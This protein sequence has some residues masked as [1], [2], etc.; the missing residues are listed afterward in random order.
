MIFIGNSKISG[1]IPREKFANLPTVTVLCAFRKM[2]EHMVQQLCLL[3]NMCYG[4]ST[5]WMMCILILMFWHGPGGIKYRQYSCFFC[6]IMYSYLLSKYSLMGQTFLR[7]R[8]LANAISILRTS[9]FPHRN[10]FS[11]VYCNLFFIV[12]YCNNLVCSWFI[13]G[14]MALSKL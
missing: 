13:Q 3:I 11:Y 8:P 12:F 1:E 2:W 14:G 6:Y 10:H 5:S 9:T 4:G 7:C